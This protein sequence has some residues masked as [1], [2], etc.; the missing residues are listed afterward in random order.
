MKEL[1]FEPTNL[2]KLSKDISLKL[3]KKKQSLPFFKK[4]IR[5][6]LGK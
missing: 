1:I 4:L 2:E 6:L 5:F 3:E